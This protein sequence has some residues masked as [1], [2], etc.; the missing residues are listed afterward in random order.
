MNDDY[1]IILIDKYTSVIINKTKSCKW[2][3]CEKFNEHSIW[4][5]EFNNKEQCFLF[6]KIMNGDNNENN[7]SGRGVGER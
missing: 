6:L 7:D 4:D 1:F 3:Y 5:L 2:R